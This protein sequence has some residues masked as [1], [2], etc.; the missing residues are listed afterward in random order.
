MLSEC[1]QPPPT[2]RRD[3]HRSIRVGIATHLGCC[4]AAALP[5]FFS[6]PGT[7]MRNATL[8]PIEALHFAS[9][10]TGTPTATANGTDLPN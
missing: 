1:R 3:V 6:K 5:Q 9:A 7:G 4:P 2:G 10:P 8:C